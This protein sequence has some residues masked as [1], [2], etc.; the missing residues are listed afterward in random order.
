[1]ATQDDFSALVHKWVAK[2][3]LGWWKIDVRGYTAYEYAKQDTEV[4]V[5]SSLALCESDWRYM[6]AVIKVNLDLL[7]SVNEED[8]EEIVVHE[9]MHVI[10]GEMHESGMAHEERVATFLA[11]SFL[12]CE[13]GNEKVESGTGE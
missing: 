7:A 13:R 2:T 5:H 4:D 12:S 9:L 8:L 10:L 6:T 3:W 1:M 11:R